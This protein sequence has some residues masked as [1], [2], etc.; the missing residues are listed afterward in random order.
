MEND[1]LEVKD[2]LKPETIL[3]L[4]KLAALIEDFQAKITVSLWANSPKQFKEVFEAMRRS[5]TL[6]TK[7]EWGS[8]S[9]YAN[10]Y[11]RLT[12]DFGGRVILELNTE[13]ANAGCRK[14]IVQKPI[15]EW[16]CGP[17][18]EGVTEG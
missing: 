1:V 10:P 17:L 2:E 13:K 11:I 12:Q 4:K 8:G 14:V 6:I 3:G 18:L 9:G 7:S 15:E 5:G 16:E